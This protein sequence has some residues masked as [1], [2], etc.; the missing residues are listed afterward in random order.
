VTVAVR[1]E[2]GDAVLSVSDDGVGMDIATQARIFEPFFTTKP[3]TNGSG[4]GL[5]TAHGIVGQSGGTIEVESEP[6]C[7]SA[8]TIRLPAVS[9]RAT[10]L[11]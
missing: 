11:D 2:G 10:L 5:S 7:G 4:L 3:M 6:G 8:F 1:G 9:V